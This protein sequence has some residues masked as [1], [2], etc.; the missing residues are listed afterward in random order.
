[1]KEKSEFERCAAQLRALAD[2]R[3]L[4]ILVE[5]LRSP[6]YVCTLAEELNQPTVLVSYHLGMLRQSGLV[7][8]TKQGRLVAYQLHPD[9]VI[10]DPTKSRTRIN[11]GYY[12]LDLSTH[13]D[14]R[15]RR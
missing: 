9:V 12:R 5:L 14:R 6:H 8:A 4:R 10:V 7:M 11:L 13:A 1:M 15:A 2:P 3:R